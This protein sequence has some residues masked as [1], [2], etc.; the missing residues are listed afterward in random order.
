MPHFFFILP[1]LFLFLFPGMR[2]HL[3]L[4]LLMSDI[5][6]H[7]C[8]WRSKMRTAKLL[9]DKHTMI[10][11]QKLCPKFMRPFFFILEIIENSNLGTTFTYINQF[12]SYLRL[13]HF[14]WQLLSR[15]TLLS[16]SW[17]DNPR[18]SVWSGEWF[19]QILNLKGPKIE[20][21][22]VIWNGQKY[23]HAYNH[24]F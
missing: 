23:C 3:F 15:L 22:Y 4:L 1:S 9:R 19:T 11:I 18:G 17:L 10:G 14:V 5:A 20:N 2:Q 24:N 7:I 6:W 16:N 13:F 8:H 12:Y 21:E